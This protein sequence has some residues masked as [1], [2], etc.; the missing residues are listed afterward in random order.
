[1]EG[2]AG[3]TIVMQSDLLEPQYPTPFPPPTLNPPKTELPEF[4]HFQPVVS[5][6]HAPY[7]TEN[8]VERHTIRKYIFNSN[9]KVLKYLIV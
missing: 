5:P 2:K 7:S 1:M 9:G 8:I 4:F 3:H 6:P